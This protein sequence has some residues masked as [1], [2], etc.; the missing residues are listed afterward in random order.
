MKYNPDN[1]IKSTAE[2]SYMLSILDVII[3]QATW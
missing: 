1:V 3:Q 2:Y